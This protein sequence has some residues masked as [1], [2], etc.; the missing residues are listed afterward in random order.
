[1]LRVKYVAKSH[2]HSLSQK[3]DEDIHLLKTGEP[4]KATPQSYHSAK[5]E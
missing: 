3:W 1:M 4:N 5:S 2:D